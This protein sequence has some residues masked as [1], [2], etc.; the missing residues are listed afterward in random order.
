MSRKG[1]FKLLQLPRSPRLKPV[2]EGKFHFHL[3]VFHK[4]FLILLVLLLLIAIEGYLNLQNID[5]MQKINQKLFI[6]S[7]INQ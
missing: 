1:L 5:Q 4:I 7:S 3:R 6:Q 2:K